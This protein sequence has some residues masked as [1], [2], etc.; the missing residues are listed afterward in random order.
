MLMHT[1]AYLGIKLTENFCRYKIKQRIK[2]GKI[3]LSISRKDLYEKLWTIGT[4][5]TAKELNVPYNKLK[6]TCTS[7]DI[8]LPT[9]S[10]WSSLHMGNEKPVQPPLP[11]PNDN[12]IVVIETAKKQIAKVPKKITVAVNKEKSSS[13]PTE[14]RVASPTKKIEK[15]KPSYFPDLESDQEKLTKI[16]NSLK[17]NKTLSNKPHKEIVGYRRKTQSYRE[18]KLKINSASGE[19]IPEV[20]PFIDSLFKALEMAGAKIVSKYDET[21]VLYKKYTFSLKFRLPCKKVTLSPEDKDYSRYNTFKYE[22]IG[23]INVEV[24]YK[25]YWRK[26]GKHEKLIKQTQ[27]MTTE[28][29]LRKVFLYIFSLPPIM[30]EEEK[31]HIL[32]EEKRLIEERERELL[33]ERR[34]KERK[35]TE[36]L[37]TNSINYFYSKLIKEYISA[38]LDETTDEYEWAMDKANWI[39]DSSKHPDDL[40]TEKDKEELLNIKTT[41]KYFL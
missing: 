25:L 9:A 26:W 19:I 29:L 31:A 17:V 16:Y 33:R 10:Y 40:L 32:E 39:Q 20:L 5:K 24:G 4:T 21:Q 23:K 22:T 3:M 6:N 27:T 12:R 28:D 11:N 35:K 37:L 41:S 7:N 36:D 15:E 18:D 8:P 2:R 13:P 1:W 34:E 38:E 30:D 14:K